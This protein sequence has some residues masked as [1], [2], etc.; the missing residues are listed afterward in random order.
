MLHEPP[1]E[2]RHESDRGHE[3][4]QG[5][6]R[7]A[8]TCADQK[9]NLVLQVGSFSSVWL[10]VCSHA[11]VN[12]LGATRISGRTAHVTDMIDLFLM[13]INVPLDTVTQIT[14]TFAFQG[15]LPVY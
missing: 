3:E 6:Q 13:L 5:G 4:L 10:S 1:Y 12:D 7:E 15:H 9:T 11:A 8:G 2:S 14:Q